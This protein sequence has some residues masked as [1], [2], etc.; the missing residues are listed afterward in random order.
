MTPCCVPGCVS[1]AHRNVSI[2]HRRM[3]EYVPAC[4]MHAHQIEK[5][6][7][8]SECGVRAQILG[9]CF[10]CFHGKKEVDMLSTCSEFGCDKKVVSRGL[11]SMHYARVRRSPEFEPIPRGKSPDP[12]ELKAE[13][14]IEDS[15][16]EEI[17]K[18]TKISSRLSDAK[19]ALEAEL[20][21]VKKRHRMK[22]ESHIAELKGIINKKE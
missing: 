5:D 21:A 2:H 9:K 7:A 18:I 15:Q 13:D 10:D 17:E 4:T 3:P 22:I 19:R 16:T 14:P 11:C 12:A 8:C 6:D 20:E 1:P